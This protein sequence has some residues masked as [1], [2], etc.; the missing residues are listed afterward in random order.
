MPPNAIS[1]PK[2]RQA[3]ITK[4]KPSGQN[5][6]LVAQQ[7]SMKTASAAPDAATSK[8]GLPCPATREVNAVRATLKNECGSSP[9]VGGT[10]T[11]C[12]RPSQK[13]SVAMNIRMPGIPNATAGPKLRR[14]NGI[15][16]EAKKLPK[17]IVQ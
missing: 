8:P 17:L 11:Y 2:A 6:G 3:V 7:A 12:L 10:R 9:R 1:A 16:S 15:S 14:N 13:I 5:A 4:W